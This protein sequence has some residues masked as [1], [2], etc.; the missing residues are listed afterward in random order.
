MSQSCSRNI[1]P[2]ITPKCP[3]PLCRINASFK[4]YMKQKKF[5]SYKL[6]SI[7]SKEKHLMLYYIQKCEDKKTV[8]FMFYRKKAFQHKCL[9]L[10]LYFISSRTWS[11][12]PLSK[13]QHWL[14]HPFSH[15]QICLFLGL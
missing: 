11:F 8:T 5:V 9:P 1:L 14:Y 12:G 7:A 2:F 10:L 6:K 3:L 4:I 15:L 13:T